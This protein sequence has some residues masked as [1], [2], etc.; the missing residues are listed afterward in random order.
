MNAIHQAYAEF[1]AADEHWSACLVKAF[2]KQAGNMRYQRAGHEHPDCAAAYQ[3]FRT[4][5][6][7]WLELVKATHIYK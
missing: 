2:G 5:N 1:K 4:T 3:Q 7:A 6:D